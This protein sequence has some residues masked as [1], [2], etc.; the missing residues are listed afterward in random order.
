MRLGQRFIQ[1]RAFFEVGVIELFVASQGVGRFA[2][3]RTQSIDFVSDFGRAADRECCAA[4]R[5][6][7]SLDHVRVDAIRQGSES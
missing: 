5:H 7:G 3:V 2:A 1:T 4:F 6:A